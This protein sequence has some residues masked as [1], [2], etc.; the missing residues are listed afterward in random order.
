MKKY[1][2]FLF[3]INKQFQNDKYR[4]YEEKKLFIIITFILTI[5]NKEQLKELLKY[6]LYRKEIFMKQ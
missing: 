4:K 5:L 6:P 3:Y 2:L 1:I